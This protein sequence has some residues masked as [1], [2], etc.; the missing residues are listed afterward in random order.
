MTQYDIAFRKALMFLG[1]QPLPARGKAVTIPKW[2]SLEITEEWLD[3]FDPSVYPNV[4][5]RCDNLVAFDLDVDD[6]K[7][8][9]VLLRCLPRRGTLLPLT[10]RREG[11]N[12][13]LV[14]YRRGNDLDETVK[15]IR[16]RKFKDSL[17]GTHMFEVLTGP[18]HQFIAFGCTEGT[19]YYWTEDGSPELSSVDDI[20]PITK[21][22]FKSTVD[23]LSKTLQSYCLQSSYKP[24]TPRRQDGAFAQRFA[25][26]WDMEFTATGGN[27]DDAPSGPIKLHDAFKIL[28]VRP[29]SAYISCHLDG[30]RPTSD[31]GAGRIRLDREGDGDIVVADFAHKIMWRLV[32]ERP[33]DIETLYG[34]DFGIDSDTPTVPGSKIVALV[35]DE[36][37]FVASEN[38]AYRVGHPCDPIG[39]GG[40]KHMFGAKERQ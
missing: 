35:P 34:K 14:V 11:S 10:R 5:A 9:A 1:W 18:S 26:T 37:V 3:Q 38:A 19:D 39:M 22:D 12:H 20:C 7:L 28:E 21:Y 30:V 29:T 17:G 25:M 31:S 36:W 2:T 16:S 8:A 27:W 23:Q 4:G 13:L 33:I 32:D 6:P 24:V 40:F 15:Y